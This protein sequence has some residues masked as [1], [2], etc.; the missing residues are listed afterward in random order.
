MLIRELLRVDTSVMFNS[1]L[2]D[3]LAVDG[4]RTRLRSVSKTS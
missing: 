3:T 2:V 4:A 1:I